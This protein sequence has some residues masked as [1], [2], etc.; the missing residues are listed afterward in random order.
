M[1][2]EIVAFAQAQVK[3]AA[4]RAAVPA[5]LCGGLRVIRPF[6]RGRAVRRAVLLARAGAWAGRRRLDLRRDRARSRHPGVASAY[7]QAT[8]TAPRPL[9]KDRSIPACAQAATFAALK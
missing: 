8:Q 6:R 7:V 9:I 4:R 3:T 1:T 2:N 5:A